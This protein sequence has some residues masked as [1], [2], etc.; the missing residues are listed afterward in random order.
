MNATN[1]LQQIERIAMAIL[2]GEKSYKG[3]ELPAGQKQGTEYQKRTYAM[4]K[5]NELINKQT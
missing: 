1:E 2:R 4:I 3:I 5:A